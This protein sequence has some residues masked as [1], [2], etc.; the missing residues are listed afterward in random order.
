MATS[1]DGPEWVEIEWT[2]L[3]PAD[4]AATCPPDTRAVPYVARARGMA[5]DPVPGAD[6]E[7]VTT[8]GRLVRGRIRDVSPGYDHSF[9]RPL[10][11]WIRMRDSIRAALHRTEERS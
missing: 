10:P 1:A 9:G 3:E 4:R 5:V 7:I 11:E 8:T 2:V 6:A